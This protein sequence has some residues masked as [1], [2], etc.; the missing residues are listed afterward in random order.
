[1]IRS[2]S[3]E[4]GPSCGCRHANAE[5]SR[6][7]FVQRQPHVLIHQAPYLRIPSSHQCPFAVLTMKLCSYIVRE[8]T[9]LAPNPFWGTCTLA[10]C[11]PNH[12]GSRIGVG[13]CVMHLWELAR[14]I[15]MFDQRT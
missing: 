15:A 8:D 7:R 11:T 14:E 3:D 9:G 2:T 10:V 6:W 4:T 12:Q 5:P 1:M 13:D